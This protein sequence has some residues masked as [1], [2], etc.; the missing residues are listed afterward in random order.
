M[1]QRDQELLDKQ[2][3][4]MSSGS[5]HYGAQMLGVVAVFCAGIAFGSFLYAY[6]D[7]PPVHLAV[8]D[9]MIA[10][11]PPPVTR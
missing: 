5:R 4:T 3:P 10:I 9:T 1:N 6:T 2:F 7:K 11:A 8:N